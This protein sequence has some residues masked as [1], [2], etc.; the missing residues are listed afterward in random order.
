GA[1]DHDLV[2][3]HV[4]D[5]VDVLDVDGALLDAGA[6]GGAGPQDVG[7][8][9][10]VLLGGADQRAL[11]LG[12]GGGGHAGQLLLGR[13]L[14]ALHRLA[15]AGEQVGGLGVR[16]VAQRHDQQL[17]GE[18]LA[19]VPGGALRLAAAALGAGGEV[20]QALPGELLDL[21]DAEDVVVTGVGEV[22]RL[23]AGGHRLQGAQGG[24]AVGLALEP[25]VGER[26]E[27]VPGD[28]HVGVER[29]GDHPDQRG[30]DLDHGDE[31]D[32]VLQ[33]AD[34]QALEGQDQRV[35]GE[36]GGLVALHVVQGALEAAQDVDRQADGEDDVLDE[37]R[38]PG[39]GAGEAGLAAGPGGQVQQPD[40]HEHGDADHRHDTDDH[41]EHPDRQEAAEDREPPV[42]LEELAARLGVG[43]RQRQEAERDEPVGDTDDAAPVHAG[44]AEELLHQGHTALVGIVGPGAGRD[45]LAQPEVPD[46]LADRACDERNADHGQYQRHDDRGELHGGSSGLRGVW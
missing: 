11:G 26:Q 1:L 18:G 10:A 36:V 24:A 16:V 37:V 15:A 33:H 45:R 28:A 19:G 17:G 20:Q 27:A 40:H 46:E 30:A 35:R 38:L 42:G 41:D 3:A 4:D 21:G 22:D 13:L 8:D 25:D 34:G 9:D 29:D 44:V 2:A 31:V 12:E 6:A 32:Q 5:V 39:G 7:V 23:A 43:R 14:L